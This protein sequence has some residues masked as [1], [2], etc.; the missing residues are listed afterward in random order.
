MVI[1]YQNII[2]DVEPDWI[3]ETGT[4]RAGLTL[5]LSSVLEFVKPEA[6]ILTVDIQ[7]AQIANLEASPGGTVAVIEL[8]SGHNAMISRPRELAEILDGIAAG[9]D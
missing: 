2:F 9:A 8:D 5:F 6:K 3:I 7:D 4:N 1:V